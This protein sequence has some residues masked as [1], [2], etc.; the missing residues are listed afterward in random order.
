M[1][2]VNSCFEL[3][4]YI[5]CLR[6]FAIIFCFYGVASR[7]KPASEKTVTRRYEIVNDQ[8]GDTSHGAVHL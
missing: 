4:F 8:K 6:R 3:R 2:W 1:L 7:K 5:G